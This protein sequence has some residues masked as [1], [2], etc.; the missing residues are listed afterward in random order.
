MKNKTFWAA[1]GK[2]LA[3]MTVM[4]IVVLALVPASLAAKY[5][6]L[7]RFYQISGQHSDGTS[8]YGGLVFDAAGNLYGTAFWGYGGGCMWHGC[9]SAFELTPNQDGTWA[10]QILFGFADW[11]PPGTWPASSLIFDAA[12]NL[13]GT[14]QQG[15]D[16]YA[17]NSPYYATGCGVVF[18][19]APNPD[20]TWTES[21]P[22]TFTGGSDGAY[23]FAAVIFDSS[24]NLYGTAPGG[25]SY[26]YGVVFKLTKNTDGTWSESV[27]HQ[28]TGEKDGANPYASL[29]FDAAGQLY[30]TTWAGGAY[31]FGTAFK[32]T[33]N[34]DG[35]W[36]EK[37]LHQFSNGADG[38][39]PHAGMV[40][41]PAG[42]LYGTTANGGK[43]GLGNVFKLWLGSD[44]IWRR[45]WLHQF[46]GGKDGAN[47]YASVALDAAGNLYGTTVNGGTYGVGTVF[48]LT[49]GTDGVWRERAMHHFKGQ[50]AR[51][52]YAGVTLDAVGNLYGT[53][54]GGNSD[55]SY[56]LNDCGAVFEITP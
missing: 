1:A 10:E 13:Y 14:A 23:P 36:T 18:M 3:A 32:L 44:G 8:P 30:G 42:N 25:G 6:V 17:C 49:L 24:G 16:T 28:F 53:T 11:G 31:G 43:Y 34:T 47:P 52:P 45:R 26:G 54:S 40:S 46:R 2:G 22:Y 5:K 38:A 9:G 37:V 55:C 50:P 20:V 35:T 41:D 19:L 33:P 29:I 27:L 21:V 12:G 51:N 4:L 39:N 48:R 15:G 56:Y 7:H